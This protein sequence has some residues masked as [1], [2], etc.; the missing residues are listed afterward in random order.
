MGNNQMKQTKFDCAVSSKT[1]QL[2]K[3]VIPY[4]NNPASQYIGT[5]IK[6]LEFQNRLD[7]Q[8]LSTEKFP[9]FST[10]SAPV[11][12]ILHQR[13]TFDTINGQMEVNN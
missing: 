1:M 6:F 5:L 3:A 10:L 8:K 7:L 2:I 9:I 12:N 13:G 11:I 4:I